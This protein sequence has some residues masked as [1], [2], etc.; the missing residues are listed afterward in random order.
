MNFQSN[1]E[2][3][4]VILSSKGGKRKRERHRFTQWL[5]QLQVNQNDWLIIGGCLA[6]FIYLY[7]AHTA[8]LFVYLFASLAT[9]SLKILIESMP[10]V[11]AMVGAKIR[12]WHVAAGICGIT[13]LLSE[14]AFPANA[15]LFQAVE[16]EVTRIIQESGS[17]VD[18]TI[19]TT[20]FTA[21]RIIV[22][23]GFLVGGIFLVNQAMQGGDWKPIGNMMGIALAFVFGIEI[24]SKLI[25][26]TAG[27]GGGGT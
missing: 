17:T 26:G 14:M 15:A 2:E 10:P 3:M 6:G 24:I 12:V 7:F 9:I 13:L 20:I 4:G 8:T 19:V 5:S 21:L 18:T 11:A 25:L 27:G 1:T 16:D 22:I 23:L